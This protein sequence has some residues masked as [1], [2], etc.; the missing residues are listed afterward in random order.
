MQL[1][2]SGIHIDVGDSLRSHVAQS[3]EATVDRYFG[4]AIEGKATFARARHLF[5]ADISVHIARGMVL[6]SHAEA[7]DAYAA[8]DAAL[9]R[10]DTRLQRHKGR[11]V[12][13]R[14][15]G[16]DGE[17]F[18]SAPYYVIAAD[19]T[20]PEDKERGAPPVVA[21]MATDIAILT[22]SEAVMRLDLAD[23]PALMFRNRAHGGLNVV[24]RRNDGAIG[25]IDPGATPSARPRVDARASKG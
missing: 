18:E 13:R 8:F 10:L 4:H 3:L 6:Q 15:G 23:Q 20:A 1:S 9:D 24:Y 11:L 14:R 7:A 21:E 2:V 5:R 16:A 22:V 17:E 12:D 25:W 19:E